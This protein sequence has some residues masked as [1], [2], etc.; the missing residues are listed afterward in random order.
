MFKEAQKVRMQKSL[1]KTMLTAYFDAKEVI[2]HEFVQKQQTVN[3]KYCK[4]VIKGLFTQVHCLRPKF[5]E[6]GSWYIL[7]DNV[8]VHSLGM[9]LVKSG[10]PML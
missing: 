6:S 1:V 2:H 8:Q 4:E 7:H 3:G 9:F 5:Q 10:I